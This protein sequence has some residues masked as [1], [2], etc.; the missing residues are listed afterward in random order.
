MCRKHTANK[1][2]LLLRLLLPFFCTALFLISGCFPDNN[3]TLD[4]EQYTVGNRDNA[5]DSGAWWGENIT[6]I[7]RHGNKTYTFIIDNSVVP[8]TAFLYEKTD[9]QEW[10]EGKSFVVS[11]P[12]NIL[13]DSQGHVQVIG[14]EPF[15]SSASMYDGRLFY[16]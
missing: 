6:K 5:Q 9:D 13:V 7:A 2:R 10:V 12:P 14:F 16:A 4:F 15:D 1:I 3:A 11:R 8:R